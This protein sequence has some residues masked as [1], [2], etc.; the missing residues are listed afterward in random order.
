MLYADDA[1]I[2]CKS[3]EGLAKMMNI[4]VTVFE[5]ACLT[6]SENK[7]ETILLWAPDQALQTSPL[8][9]E[10]AGQRYK[11]ATQLIYLG[12]PLN[13]SADIMPEIKLRIRLARGCYKR[14]QREVYDVEAAPF[15]LKVRMLKAE[16][17]ET[18]LYECATWT[19]GKELFVEL[20]TV[21]HRFILRA[22]RF[23]RRQRT[24]CFMSY[25]K[26]LKKARWESVEATICKLH[27]LSAGAVLRT[28]NER[29]T[30]RDMFGTMAGGENPGPGRPEK[31]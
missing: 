30:R 6:V 28:N 8:V 14:F 10:A 29:L 23:Q 13:T 18:L 1:G 22:I 7:T 19:L 4:I 3:A 31:R 9:V 21:H 5:A 26:A 27:L 17:M 24:D 2:V 25:A 12:G 15:R 16:V 11:Q 20:R